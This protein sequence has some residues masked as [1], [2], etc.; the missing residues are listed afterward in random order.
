MQLLIDGQPP[1]GLQDGSGRY[2]NGAHDG[3]AGG[4]AVAILSRGGATVQAVPSGPTG[5][6]AGGIM[7]V[8][9]A[10]FEQDA[11]AGLTTTHRSRRQRS[12]AIWI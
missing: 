11:F 7:A 12:V 9:D 3:T 5:G 2:I 8:I 6:Q 10:L 1:S 4:N